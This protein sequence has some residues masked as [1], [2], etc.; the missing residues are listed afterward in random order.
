[1]TAENIPRK[2]GQRLAYLG[3][4]ARGFAHEIKN[5]LS[6]MSVN[7]QM[8]HDDLG[9][10]QGPREK[11]VLRRVEVLEREVNRLE[12]IVNDFLTFARGYQLQPVLQPVNPMLRE[13]M[14]FWAEDAR[15]TGIEAE[16]VLAPDLP[17]V[18]LDSGAFKQTILNLLINAQQAIVQQ[19]E[20]GARP[21]QIVVGTRAVQGGVEVLVIDSGP[22]IPEKHLPRIF[23]PYYS[24]KPRGSGLGLATARRI[25]EE[26]GGTLTVQ[27]EVGRGTSFRILIPAANRSARGEPVS[28][29]DGA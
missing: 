23:D 25:I 28:Q 15:E 9:D 14:E 8:M 13:I 3:S 17:D 21:E 24:T 29:S 6:A 27:S 4:L 5:P 22:G 18:V 20:R 1:M 10:A 26:H 2:R 12:K 19:K 11:R 16:L 7:L